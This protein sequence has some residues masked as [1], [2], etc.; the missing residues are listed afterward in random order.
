MC[1]KNTSRDIPAE[2]FYANKKVS[3]A[4]FFVLN[5]FITQN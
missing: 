3:L 5:F 4:D 1:C 2:A